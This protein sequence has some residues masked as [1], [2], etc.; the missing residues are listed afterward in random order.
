MSN[1]DEFRKATIRAWIVEDLTPFVGTPATELVE[2]SI[3]VATVEMLAEL[4]R[5]AWAVAY[6]A[7]IW[8]A[9]PGSVNTSTLVEAVN[10]LTP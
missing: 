7:T 9:S 10:A 5:R 3:K 4:D 8:A 6:A 1:V 2:M